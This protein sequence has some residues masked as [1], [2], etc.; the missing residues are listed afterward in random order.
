[1]NSSIIKV[2]EHCVISSQ[3]KDSVSIRSGGSSGHLDIAVK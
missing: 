3:S 1:M 2:D